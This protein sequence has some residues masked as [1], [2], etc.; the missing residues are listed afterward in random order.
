LVREIQIK[1]AVY[2]WLDSFGH[3]NPDIAD[4]KIHMT[5]TEVK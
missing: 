3:S 5:V 2:G 1:G 4:G